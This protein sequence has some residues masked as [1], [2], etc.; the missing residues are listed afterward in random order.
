MN[1]ERREVRSRI[2]NIIKDPVCQEGAAASMRTLINSGISIGDFVPV[3][4]AIFSWGAD[5]LKVTRRIGQRVGVDLKFLDLTPDV[6]LGMAIGTELL[7]L[8][9]LGHAPTHAIETFLQLRA[10][11]PRMKKAVE[12]SIRHWRGE[13]TDTAEQVE[14]VKPNPY[15]GMPAE[16]FLNNHVPKP[17]L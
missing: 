11:A 17:L 12:Q 6:G 4:G 13:T 8:P 3:V 5:G 16:E 10:D 1:L 9:T 15:E 2:K 14:I 7:E